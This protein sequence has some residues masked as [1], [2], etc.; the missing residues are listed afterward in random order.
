MSCRACARIELIEPSTR[1]TE[2]AGRDPECPVRRLIN[3]CNIV[4]GQAGRFRVIVPVVDG[5][6]GRGVEL[7]EPG[8][9]HAKCSR[10]DPK[11]GQRIF[12]N[13]GDGIVTQAIRIVRVMTEVIEPIL[14]GPKAV[15]TAECPHPEYTTRVFFNRSDNIITKAGWLLW[16]MAIA[17]KGFGDAVE[18][19]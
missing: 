9:F 11:L 19:V 10:A 18:A 13:H 16:V 8:A 5:F 7:T 6:P 14:L 17:D 4:A 12:K 1:Q 15:Q 3:G 2:P